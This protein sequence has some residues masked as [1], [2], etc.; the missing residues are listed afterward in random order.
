MT[1]QVSDFSDIL[2]G[3]PEDT[4]R[5]I[6]RKP[7]T[8]DQVADGGES[9]YPDGIAFCQN[10]AGFVVQ[11]RPVLDAVN[12]CCD[13]VFHRFCSVAVGHDGKAQIVG[14]GNEIMH[15]RTGQRFLRQHAVGGEIH[16]AGDHQLD[17]I[18][19]ACLRFRQ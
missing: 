17:E 8:A 15:L 16:Q 18:R 13:G 7:P 5:Y 19:P 4:F 9:R 1:A 6:V 2:L 10:M 3:R 11:I 12:L 14:G